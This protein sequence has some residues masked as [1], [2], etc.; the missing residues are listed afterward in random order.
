MEL[1]NEFSW[2]PPSQR[3]CPGLALG[4]NIVTHIPVS[5]SPV[6]WST[7]SVHWFRFIPPLIRLLLAFCIRYSY[8]AV[9]GCSRPSDSAA[10]P[11][12]AAVVGIAM[13]WHP[14]RF[15]AS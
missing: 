13:L 1:C 11:P 2:W 14:L 6:L 15:Q 4:R 7:N 8:V 9:D 3:T 10:R 12:Q 5:L